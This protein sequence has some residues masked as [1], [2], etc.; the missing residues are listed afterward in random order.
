[1]PAPCGQLLDNTRA[2]YCIT[3]GDWHARVLPVTD[4]DWARTGGAI[5]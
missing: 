5:T 1:M 2:A 4:G 3:D